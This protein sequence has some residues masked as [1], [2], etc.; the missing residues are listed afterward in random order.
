MP[1]RWRGRPQGRCP[2][3]ARARCLS[4]RRPT[5][6]RATAPP[7][8]GPPPPL[9]SVAWGPHLYESRRWS[10]AVPVRPDGY[11]PPRGRRRDARRPFGRWFAVRPRAARRLGRWLRAPRV[12]RVSRARQVQLARGCW[13]RASATARV[14]ASAGRVR[15]APR[16]EGA[17]APEDR[18]SGPSRH[19]PFPAVHA[20]ARSTAA[21]RR[22][23]GRVTGAPPESRA[24]ADPSGRSSGTRSPPRTPS[25]GP[26][27]P[28][29][30]RLRRDR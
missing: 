27:S 20:T 17:P 5:V 8:R 7:P 13:E 14:P 15:E 30:S 11:A 9:R 25:G 16:A 22:M 12:R 2:R 21:P 24:R 23:A 10:P 26:R 19:L 18:G 3:G 28:L 6:G 1:P 29:R 4:C